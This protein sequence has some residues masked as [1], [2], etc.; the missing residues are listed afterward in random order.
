MPDFKTY[1]EVKQDAKSRMDKTLDALKKDFSGLRTGRASTALLEGVTVEAYGATSPLSAVGTI[2][3]P[4][5]RMLSV[6]VWDKSLVKTVEKAIRDAGLGLN[7]MN[8]GQLIRVPIPALTEERRIE[9]TKIASKY[10]EQGRVAV[11]NVRRDAMDAV[12][13]MQKDGDISEDD[14]KRYEAEIQT[15]TDNA[16]KALDEAYKNKEQ[17]IKQV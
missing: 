4:E 1:A 14:L 8:D 9:L 17:E 2:S 11:R 6:Q 12:K 13:K 5:P 7:P 15:M 3:V 10:T 16:V